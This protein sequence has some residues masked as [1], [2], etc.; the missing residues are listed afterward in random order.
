LVVVLALSTIINGVVNTYSTAL[1]A[2]ALHPI[3][4]RVPRVLWVLLAFVTYTVAAVAGREHFSEILSNA[5][6]IFAYWNSLFLAILIEEH[7]IFRRRLWGR[8][9]PIIPD[10]YD[11]QVYD[12][13]RLLPVGYAAIGAGACG[14]AGFVVGMSE[15]YYTGPIGAM[16]GSAGGDLGFELAAAFT[17]VTYPPLRYLELKRVGR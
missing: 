13:P 17:A 11:L 14:V 1:A 15:V 6:A 10:G 4:Q 5:L 7:Y 12:K 9:E 3:C 2:Q 8:R 16:I